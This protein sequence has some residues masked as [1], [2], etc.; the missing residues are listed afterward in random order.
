MFKVLRPIKILVLVVVF[1][2]LAVIAS[3]N[4]SG[5]ENKKEELKNGIF[6]QAGVNLFSFISNLDTRFSF[7]P[8]EE[9]KFNPEEMLN[10]SEIQEEFKEKIEGINKENIFSNFKNNSQVELENIQNLKDSFLEELNSDQEIEEGEII[11][12]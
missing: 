1:M 5:N 4:F 7:S 2:V 6:W 12:D 3:V 11:E 10:F 9:K 8:Q